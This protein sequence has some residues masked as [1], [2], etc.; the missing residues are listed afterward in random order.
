M[1]NR[2]QPDLER[3][4][5]AFAGE[6]SELLNG[7]VTDGIPLRW[8]MDPHGRA[9]V[10]YNASK[11]NPLGDPI[12][13]TISQSPARLHLSVLNTLDLDASGRFLATSKSTYTLQEADA[14][15]SILTYDFVRE[16]PNVYPEAHFHLHGESDALRR[17]LLLCGRTKNK[18][19][20]LHIPVG[21]RRFRPC[22]EDVIEFCVL[23]RLVTPRERWQAVLND[24][25]GRY[26]EKQLEAAVRQDPSR[27]A[28]VLRSEGWHVREPDDRAA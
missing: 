24:S 22:L 1:P 15:A 3:Q 2:R 27:A 28:D 4:A 14:T 19:D 16:P 9:V 12:P 26:Y 8:Y 21:G 23:E 10:G 6:L 5:R 25:R 7:T 11:E 20:D 18:P 13:L 17:V